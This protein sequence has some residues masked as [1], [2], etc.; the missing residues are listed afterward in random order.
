MVLW[1]TRQQA[2]T[3]HLHSNVRRVPGCDI[4]VCVCVVF[5]LCMSCFVVIVAQS[6]GRVEEVGWLCAGCVFVVFR[7]RLV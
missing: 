1:T 2:R 3:H 4:Q 7:L 6:V 5:V